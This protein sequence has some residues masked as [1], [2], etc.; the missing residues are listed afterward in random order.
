MMRGPPTSLKEERNLGITR[1]KKILI[2]EP[3]YVAIAVRWYRLSLTNS[4]PQVL[5]NYQHYLE[6]AEEMGQC[7]RDDLGD[8]QEHF[9]GL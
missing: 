1:L 7:V 4:D 9:L 8:T 2:A 6:V 5:A 3:D